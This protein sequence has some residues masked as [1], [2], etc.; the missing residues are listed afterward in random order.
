MQEHA[1]SDDDDDMGEGPESGYTG[2]EQPP[3]ASERTAGL[4]QLWH[5]PED[6]SPA[7]CITCMAWN[8]VRTSHPALSTAPAHMS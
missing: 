8:P 3:V 2:G 4:S 7:L 1:L 6:R 5:W